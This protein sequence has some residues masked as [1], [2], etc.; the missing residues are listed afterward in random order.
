MTPNSNKGNSRYSDP[1]A[2]RIEAAKKHREALDAE[3]CKASDVYDGFYLRLEDLTSE[4]S[5]FFLGGQA[6]IGSSLLYDAQASALLSPENIVLAR[7]PKKVAQ[8]LAD[9]ASAG[10]QIEPLISFIA[11]RAQDKTALVDLAFLCWNAQ[12]EEYGPSLSAFVRGITERVANG[13]RAEINISQDQFIH[14][15]RSGG[16]WYLTKK[17]KRDP[18]EKGAVSYKSRRSGTERITAYA[19]KHR[20]GCNVLASIFWLAVAFGLVCLVWALFFSGA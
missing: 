2:S 9:H 6:I 3:F 11:F 10:W 7:L 14:V 8:R 13:D 17:T 15:V 12:N 16:T 20:V 18:L 19:L 5:R 1:M 4:G